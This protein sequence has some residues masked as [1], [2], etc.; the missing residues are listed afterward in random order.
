MMWMHNVRTDAR[1][2]GL[3]GEGR[4]VV[5][6]GLKIFSYCGGDCPVVVVCC[7]RGVLFGSDARDNFD[8]RTDLDTRDARINFD[9]RNDLDACAVSG[10]TASR[11]FSCRF[12]TYCPASVRSSFFGCLPQTFCPPLFA[13]QTALLV[14]FQSGRCRVRMPFGPGFVLFRY[15]RVLIGCA[16][17]ATFADPNDSVYEIDFT[18]FAVVRAVLRF[19]CPTARYALHG[20]GRGAFRRGR[21]AQGQNVRMGQGAGRPACDFGIPP[22]RLR[23]ER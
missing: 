1:T 9:A 23:M 13:S 2:V 16:E 3:G 20:Y 4:R 21:G 5:K 18:S 10:A 14:R 19:L 11:A 22:D 12:T 6:N 15:F 17:F 7:G 8:A